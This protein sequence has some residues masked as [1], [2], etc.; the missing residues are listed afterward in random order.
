MSPDQWTEHPA[1][2]Q[3]KMARAVALTQGCY[4]PKTYEFDSSFRP[5]D[6]SNPKTVHTSFELAEFLSRNPNAQLD[7]KVMGWDA[8]TETW[9][10][11]RVTREAFLESFEDK[12]KTWENV[13]FREQV[14]GFN[15]VVS[16][17]LSPTFSVGNDFTPLLGG[18]FFKNLYYYEDYIRMHSEAFYA[19]NNDPVAHAVT[20]ITKNFT[21]GTGFEVQCDT[22]DKRG[23]LAMAIWKSFEEVND[24]QSQI[25]SAAE[26]ISIYGEVMWWKLPYVNGFSQDKIIYR[27]QP[28][29]KIPYGLIPRVRLLDPSNLV[30]IVTYPEDISRVL[31]YCWLTPTQYQIFT[32]GLGEG[33]PTD[34][35]SIQPSL[36]FIY[37]TIMADQ[38][39]HY[40]INTVT[41]EKR[42]RS[43]YF[44]I[45]QYMKRLRD[46]VDYQLIGL[47]KAAAWAIDTTVDGDQNDILN[48]QQAMAA[49]GTIPAAGSEF[50]HT[51]KIKREL[52]G[53]GGVKINSEAFSLALSMCAIGT[54]I[55]VSW[56]GT[57]LSGGATRAGALVS[58]EPVVK[59]MEK[60]REVLKRMIRD[61]WDY[62]MESAGIG[63]I[64][65]DII[66][67]EIITQDRSQKLKDLMLAENQRWLAPMTVATIAAKELQVQN[68][69]YN[70]EIEKMKEE[71]P[72]VPMPL[73]APPS[74]GGITLGGGSSG[75]FN[76]ANASDDSET[77]SSQLTSQYKRSVKLNDTSL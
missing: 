9:R 26:E 53:G 54:T 23:Q 44:P 46:S 3:E 49:L 35:R 5:Y 57:H 20:S 13:E 28:G 17:P 11:R 41:G 12:N 37:R 62:V 47:Q 69:D 36:K 64:H 14:S 48:Y 61:L 31:F 4:D 25:D 6:P 75:G 8:K 68:Y 45:F 22:S 67:P 30:E 18:P 2:K 70:A 29:D 77:E 52:L 71:L 51:T 60:R 10:N 42:G 56:F 24:I 21:L 32:G 33:R 73:T 72:K 15:T 63:K 7:A 59:K 38:M 43:D 76:P 1:P 65:C 16:S 34:Q 19:K 66:L 39:L 74:G 27:L 58:T 40:K 50:V 55:P